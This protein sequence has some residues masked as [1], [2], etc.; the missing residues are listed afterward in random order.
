MT[1]DSSPPQGRARPPSVAYASIRREIKTGDVLMFA[2][3]SALSS[4]I[5]DLTGSEF[6][7]AGIVAL[8]GDRV[9]VFQS[10]AHGSELLPA[11]R[12]VCQY[13]G[14]VVWYGLKDPV[15][16]D[17]LLNEALNLLRLRYSFWGLVRFAWK[18]WTGGLKNGR[19]RRN[20]RSAMFCSQYVSQ[21]FRVAGLDLVKKRSDDLTS[22]GDIARSKH[23]E[24]RGVLHYPERP[25][26]CAQLLGRS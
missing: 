10:S 19:D 6:S 3:K 23:L 9:M 14:R 16:T 5:K 12:V 1:S 15:D 25:G 13:D 22:P 4:T 21:V 7:H 2:G 8:W 24:P 11:S 26:Y 20:A 18:I 17:K